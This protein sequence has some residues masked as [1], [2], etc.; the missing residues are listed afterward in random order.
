MKWSNEAY[1]IFAPIYFNI[2]HGIYKRRKQILQRKMKK[3]LYVFL[4]S[5]TYDKAWSI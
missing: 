3:K 4:Y 2:D 1:K 5:R